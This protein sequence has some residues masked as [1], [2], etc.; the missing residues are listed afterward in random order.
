MAERAGLILA[1]TC[2]FTHPTIFYIQPQSLKIYPQIHR[3]EYE[4]VRTRGMKRGRASGEGKGSQN[5]HPHSLPTL[6]TASLVEH[7]YTGAAVNLSLGHFHG[8]RAVS[9]AARLLVSRVSV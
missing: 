6:H 3:R 2:A 7:G 5:P 1:C 8:V 9:R 4:S